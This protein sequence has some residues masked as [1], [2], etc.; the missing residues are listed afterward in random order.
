MMPCNS[1]W[2][3]QSHLWHSSGRQLQVGIISLVRANDQRLESKRP[4][5]FRYG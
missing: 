2:R 3:R 5:L 1:I 4:N